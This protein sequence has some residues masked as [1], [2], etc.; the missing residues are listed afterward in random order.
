MIIAIVYVSAISIPTVIVFCCVVKCRR[1]KC[2]PYL[3]TATLLAE[4][5]LSLTCMVL[6]FVSGNSY[7]KRSEQLKNLDEAVNGCTD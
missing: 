6:A 3:V 2:L 7:G 5:A 1:N 4:C